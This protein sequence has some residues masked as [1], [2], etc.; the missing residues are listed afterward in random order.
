MEILVSE[1]FQ[2]EI[3][4]LLGEVY[5]GIWN[6]TTPVALKKLHEKSHMDAFL[7]EAALLQ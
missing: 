7:K 4:T 1:Y 6:A 3:Y 2:V 5:E